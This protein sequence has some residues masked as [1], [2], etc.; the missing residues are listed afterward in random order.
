ITAA[1]ATVILVRA[2]IF[3]VPR[4]RTWRSCM[5]DALLL[6]WTRPGDV[7]PS[8]IF[9]PIDRGLWQTTL[10]HENVFGKVSGT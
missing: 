5:G 9:H 1:S 8:V 3:R 4:T 7:R 2:W 10:T 6:S